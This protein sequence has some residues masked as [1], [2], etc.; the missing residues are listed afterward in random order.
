M[1]DRPLESSKDSEWLLTL[2]ILTA[3]LIVLLLVLGFGGFGS[4]KSVAPP[5]PNTQ[6]P[7]TSGDVEKP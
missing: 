3:F 2:G 7:A 1:A 5:Q 4:V 6:A